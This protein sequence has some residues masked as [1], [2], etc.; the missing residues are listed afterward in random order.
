M[1]FLCGCQP[2][3]YPSSS[4]SAAL[5]LTPLSTN[6]TPPQKSVF[7]LSAPPRPLCPCG[8]TA[9]SFFLSLILSPSFLGEQSLPTGC[10]IRDVL[11]YCKSDTTATMAPFSLPGL[12]QGRKTP[13]F[14]CCKRSGALKPWRNWKVQSD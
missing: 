11:Y 14:C 2:V 3:A 10:A 4:L 5:A 12:K 7:L 6:T 1:Y 9:A 13:V 8:P